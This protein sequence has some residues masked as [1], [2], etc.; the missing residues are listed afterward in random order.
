V[1][2][3]FNDGVN[4]RCNDTDGENKGTQRKTCP[5][6]PT[7]IGSSIWDGLGLNAG[8]HCER[9]ATANLNHGT[10]RIIPDSGPLPTW[11]RDGVETNTDEGV[12]NCWSLDSLNQLTLS[13]YAHSIKFCPQK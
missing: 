11:R 9:Q 7:P 5:S 13:I 4:C 3:L 2:V 6:A 8:L 1:C 10:A 12:T